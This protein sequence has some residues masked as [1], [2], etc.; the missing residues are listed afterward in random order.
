MASLKKTTQ[1][2]KSTQKISNES[3]LK[4]TLIKPLQ[5]KLSETVQRGS[6]KD[7]TLKKSHSFMKSTACQRSVDQ[8][9]PSKRSLSKESSKKITRSVTP[10]LSRPKTPTS[11]QPVF[12]NQFST[13][14]TFKQEPIEPAILTRSIQKQAHVLNQLEVPSPSKTAQINQKKTIPKV[15]IFRLGAVIKG[16]KTRRIL[17]S[18]PSVS[19]LKKEY[20]DLLSF[21]FGL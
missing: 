12:K 2:S 1:I 13:I 18:H 11:A 8:K 17:K 21:T 5:T 19:A 4:T 14:T 16:Y 9:P 15:L 3:K 20:C 6:S 10:N 7:T